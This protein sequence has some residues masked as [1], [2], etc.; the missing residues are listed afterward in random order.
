[1]RTKIQFGLLQ[2]TYWCS[3]GSFTCFMAA[4][5]QSEG[6]P[7]SGISVMVVCNTMTAFFGQFFFGRLCDR[8]KS[9]RKVYLVSGIAVIVLELLIFQTDNRILIIVVYAALGFIQQPMIA[10]LDTWILKS[11]RRTPESYGPIRSAGALSFAVIVFITGGILEKYGYFYMFIFSAGFLVVGTI[12]AFGA[13]DCT[14]ETKEADPAVNKKEVWKS[15]FGSREYTVV[16]VLLL[17][18]GIA[19]APVMQLMAVIMEQAGGNVKF[20]G[21]AMFV[22]AAVQFPF[23]L[24]AGKPHRISSRGRLTAAAWLY[25]I[26]LIGT[27]FAET[28]WGILLFSIMNGMAYGILLP[29]FRELLFKITPKEFVTTAQGTADAV[30]NSIGSMLSSMAAGVIISRYSIKVLLLLCAL[31]QCIAV[32]VFMAAG[33]K[34][35]TKRE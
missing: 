8:M 33:R 16:L 29:A 9:H 11:F 24:L 31:I 21:Y 10:N 13:K 7:V 6:M 3:Y 23:M 20:V 5:M 27:A 34:I 2:I 1:M 25:C 19:A 18:A 14:P 28:K 22:S 17:G 30:Y 35:Y 12:A 32:V 15:L 4:Y 26:M